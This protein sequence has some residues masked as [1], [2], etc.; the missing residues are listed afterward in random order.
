MEI[1]FFFPF[2]YICNSLSKPDD[3]ETERLRIQREIEELENTLGANA[4]LAGVLE[5]K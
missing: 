1:N 5:G 3:L 4:A 2:L